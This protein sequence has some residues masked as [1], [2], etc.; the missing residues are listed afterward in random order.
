M[1]QYRFTSPARRRASWNIEL[2]TPLKELVDRNKPPNV[3]YKKAYGEYL[4]KIYMYKWP[5]LQM[6]GEYLKNPNQRV[7]ND[8]DKA[9]FQY[10]QS[11]IRHFEKSK[12][13][14]DYN[15]EVADDNFLFDPF[16]IIEAP[17][18]SLHNCFTSVRPS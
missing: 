10:M 11:C 14:V 9:F 15:K 13:E 1:S 12:K 7:S 17:Y 8:M 18:T 3:E 5:I 6:T 4:K 16:S 2:T